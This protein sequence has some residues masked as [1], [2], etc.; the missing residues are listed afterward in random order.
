[1]SSTKKLKTDDLPIFGKPM[2]NISENAFSN[3]VEKARDF[4]GCI[5]G[6]RYFAADAVMVMN[7]GW[8]D[9]TMTEIIIN[10]DTDA[11]VVVK[12]TQIGESIFFDKE[13]ADAIA[14]E[15]NLQQKAKCK[16]ISDFVM[17]AYHQFDD[18]ILAHRK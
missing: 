3:K 16:E 2:Y 11:E 10:A 18:I 1:M 15:L 8:T 9:E 5:S 6:I 14:D 13:E 17:N 12:R 4:G 7:V